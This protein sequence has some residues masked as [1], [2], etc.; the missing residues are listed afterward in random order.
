MRLEFLRVYIC[1]SFAVESLLAPFAHLYNW[2]IGFSILM[3]EGCVHTRTVGACGCL[4]APA[5]PESCDVQGL[6]AALLFLLKTTF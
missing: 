4:W 5:S 6:N 2:I 3:S 1:V